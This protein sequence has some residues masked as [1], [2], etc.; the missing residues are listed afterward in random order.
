MITE[1]LRTIHTGMIALADNFGLA[2]GAV[3]G[4]GRVE[5]STLF[6]NSVNISSN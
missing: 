4:D 1:E 3:A 2:V 5:G 6:S